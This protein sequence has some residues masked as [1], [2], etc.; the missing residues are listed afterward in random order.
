MCEMAISRPG[1]PVGSVEFNLLIWRFSFHPFLPYSKEETSIEKS[2]EK[3][4]E[5]GFK[6]PLIPDAHL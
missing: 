2:Q 3:E 6:T 1:E 5:C 4:P